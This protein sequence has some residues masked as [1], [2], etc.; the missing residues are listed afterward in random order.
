M[1]PRR[2]RVVGV[3][4]TLGLLADMVVPSPA[5]A[6]V[7]N[8]PLSKMPTP[9]YGT[10]HLP[11]PSQ[12][13]ARVW[14]T[15]ASGNTAYVGGEFTSLAPTTAGA[16]AL[17]GQSGAPQPGFPKVDSGQVNVAAS[18][19][20][21]GWYVGG[22]FPTLNNVQV[23]GL[24][25]ILADGS[26]D[27]NFTT[28]LVGPQN[29]PSKSFAVTALALNGPW[30]YVGGEFTK[31]GA[32]GT[33]KAQARNHIARVSATSGTVDASWD[34][35]TGNNNAPNPVRSIAASPDGATV[36]FSGN[37]TS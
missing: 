11:S 19:G 2:G 5:S 20:H 13:S 3:L 32:R 15:A 21:G 6:E 7:L 26:L 28:A 35:D 25:H 18:D 37:F 16:G 24:A 14:A 1:C 29:Q 27:S 9:T 8:I 33:S 34:P 4:T 31:F 36:Y 10:E 12:F 30:L 17:D 22:S 23:N